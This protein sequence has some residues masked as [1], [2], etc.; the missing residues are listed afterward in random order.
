VLIVSSAAD[1]ARREYNEVDSKY[2]DIDNEI[3]LV[4]QL[5]QL[6]GL[7]CYME[8]VFASWLLA[9]W[10]FAIFRALYYHGLSTI[11]YELKPVASSK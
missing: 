9:A 4:N 7:F 3:K 6:L 8:F 11:N 10:F 1:Q 5:N 2:R